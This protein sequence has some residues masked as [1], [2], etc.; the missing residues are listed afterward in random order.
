MTNLDE[1]N[2][3]TDYPES[4]K[5]IIEEINKHRIKA[6]EK[7]LPEGLTYEDVKSELVETL[8]VYHTWLDHCFKYI[9]DSEKV[10]GQQ[11][12]EIKSKFE[13]NVLEELFNKELTI[14][15][16]AFV[17]AWL[18]NFE[19]TDYGKKNN[20]D[21]FKSLYNHY[22][23]SLENILKLNGRLED[24][25]WILEGLNKYTSPTKFS[26]DDFIEKAAEGV[27][28]I[29][30]ESTEGRLGGGLYDGLTLLIQ[31]TIQNDKTTLLE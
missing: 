22:N 4:V 20:Q 14:I 25:N 21:T 5:K 28:R 9:F 3:D 12:K 19:L 23:H 13:Q 15:R 18:Q 1:S 11:V 27:A 8:K 6:F 16:C 29:P 2:I 7:T 26:H 17:Y 31:N 30:F 24:K 10:I